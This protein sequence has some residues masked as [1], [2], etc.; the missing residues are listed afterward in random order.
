MSYICL[1]MAR[2]FTTTARAQAFIRQRDR[3]AYRRYV[4]RQGRGDTGN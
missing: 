3:R 4:R 1:S 2:G